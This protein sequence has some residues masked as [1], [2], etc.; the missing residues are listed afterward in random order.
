MRKN[1]PL[2]QDLIDSWKHVQIVVIDEVSFLNR[3][4]Y[5]DLD[6]RLRD[7]GDN[8]LAFGGFSIIFAGD[9]CQFEPVKST[10]EQL[11]FSSA[12]ES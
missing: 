6:T 8:R 1:K 2:P 9:F 5:D 7:I 10:P 3:S 11:L 12:S 4:E